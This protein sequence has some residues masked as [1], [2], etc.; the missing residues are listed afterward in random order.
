MARPIVKIVIKILLTLVE[1]NICWRV[2]ESSFQKNGFCSQK[3]GKLPVTDNVFANIIT[4]EN[5]ER[6]VE[7]YQQ[8]YGPQ[9]CSFVWRTLLDRNTNYMV[10][11]S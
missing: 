7:P 6:V 11:A 10:H 1:H 8:V 5:V 3:H 2:V 9:L 4:L